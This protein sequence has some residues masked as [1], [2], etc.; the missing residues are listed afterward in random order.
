M[1]N[2]FWYAMVILALAISGYALVQYLFIGADKAG[3]M[4]MKKDEVLPSIWY[5]ALYL[6]VIGS[7]ISLA[8]G[9]FLFI[10]KIRI[11]KISLHRQLGK[12]YLLGIIIG[13]FSGLYMAFYATGG[14][15]SKTGFGMLSLVW[16]LTGTMAYISILNKH[17]ELHRNWI[18]R[19]YA[20]SLAAVSLRIWMPVFL[21]LFGIEN[22]HISYI[23]I[24][25]ISWVPNLVVAEIIISRSKLKYISV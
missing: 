20:L 24:S 14:I 22:F 9:P 4:V 3:F 16:L 19:N 5:T 23:V 6:H 17:I 18:I 2:Y 21:I 8:I 15:V 1:K 11:K 10:E 13:G 7:S 25:W 12:F